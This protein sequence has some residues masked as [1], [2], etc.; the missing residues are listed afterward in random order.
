MLYRFVKILMR[1]AVGMFYRHTL[2]KNIQQVP[3][4]GPAMLIANHPSSLMD[5]ALLGIV[6]KRPVHFFARGDIFAHPIINR[7]LAALH[8]HP[9]HHHEA[10]RHTLGANDQTI[11]TA[12]RLL[13][14]GKLVLFFPEGVSHTDYHLWPFKKGA[15]RIALQALA[16]KTDMTLPVIPIGFNYSHPTRLFS[17]VWIHIG[18]PIPVNN[19]LEE[20]REQPASAIR[21]LTT[22]AFHG[23][24]DIVVQSGKN[25]ASQLFEVLDIWRHSLAAADLPAGER[26]EMEMAIAQ[27]QPKWQGEISPLL[28]QYHE[29][30]AA[31]H[32]S[33]QVVAA[34]EFPKLSKTPMAM[35]FPAA[36]IGWF[37]NALPL[38][39]ARWITDKKVRR[40]DFYSWILVAA[41]ALLYLAW[42][43]LLAIAS[44][45]L[46]PAWKALALLFITLATGQYCWNYFGFYQDWKQQQLAKKLP[47]NTLRS[48][49]A[50]RKS[51]L[52]AMSSSL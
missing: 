27:A 6:L 29:L 34:A 39:T 49:Q 1:T 8:M 45:L 16:Q 2:V 23:V 52:N 13:Q 38:L 24:K 21:L 17:T 19:Y 15:F 26:I 25:E 20:Y 12:I 51:I 10:G 43:T 28:H 48:L 46:L 40:I 30:L 42:I 14:E 3:A 35:G 47:A 31:A 36:L 50:I 18:H 33:D 4:S 44:F 37:L 22:R 11:D 7:I 41:S 9:V 32:S 5:A